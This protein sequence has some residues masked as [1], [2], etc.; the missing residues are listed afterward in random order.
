MPL[1]LTMAVSDYAHT[2][3]LVTGRVRAVGIDLNILSYPFERV[4][5]R[6]ALG[7]E[8]DIA[9]FSL[10]GYCAHVASGAPRQMVGFPV[11]P[12]RVFRQSGF[13]V[14]AG[15]GIRDVGDLRGRRIGIPQWAQTAVVYARGYLVQEVDIPLTEVEWVQAG[16]NQPG[17]KES[18]ELRLPN[19]IRLT[20]R[21]DR[22]LSDMLAS[23]EI[24]AV[25]SARAPDCFLR[26]HPNV[27]RLFGDPRA[28]ERDYF[29][30]TG[31]FPI[32]H[33]MVVR[34]DVFAKNRW[35]LRNLMDAF[36]VAKRAAL[37]RIADSTTS[38]LPIPWGPEYMHEMHRLVFPEGDPWPYGIESNRRTLE[39]FLRYCHE[40]YVT[41]RRLDPSD[42]FPPECS[43]EVI[44]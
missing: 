7:R 30:R 42:L 16:V 39:A 17:R 1:P 11:F 6:F 23:G 33:V 35:V 29:H 18:V 24:D 36:E 5:L 31:I 20:A 10:A 40:Q 13:F 22:C 27:R 34:E 14:N 21:P 3:D 8:F 28:A 12:S 4:G 2:H 25:I 43:L 9:E 15:A 26:G 44:V 32:M 38:Y 41:S 19:D 37:G